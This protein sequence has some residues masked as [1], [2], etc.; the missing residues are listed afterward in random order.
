MRL[1]VL[2]T[3]LL[4]IGLAAASLPKV[5]QPSTRS[6]LEA[7]Q[8]LGPLSGWRCAN[9]ATYV[10]DPRREARDVT[11]VGDPPED[12]VR[13]L[14]SDAVVERAEISLRGGDAVLWTTLTSTVSAERRVYV[15]T[16]GALQAVGDQPTCYAHQGSWRI[17]AEH[18]L[19]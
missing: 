9:L 14:R 8:T 15:L 17:V 5:F 11:L 4:V 7:V 12:A 6:L 10:Y 13:A 3:A 1:V 16:P 19:Q 2:W 18:D